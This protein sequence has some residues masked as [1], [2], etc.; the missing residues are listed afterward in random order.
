MTKKADL[1]KTDTD[2][3]KAR[4]LATRSAKQQWTRL[5]TDTKAKKKE[6]RDDLAK[7]TKAIN[8]HCPETE[9]DLPPD[10]KAWLVMN[11]KL[12]NDRKAIEAKKKRELGK[13]KKRLKRAWAAWCEL[14]STE[15]GDQVPMP[16]GDATLA[17]GL[18]CSLASAR[19]VYSEILVRETSGAKLG[20]DLLALKAHLER[21]EG[22]TAFT[23]EEDEEGAEDEED[24][25]D[26]DED[27]EPAEASPD[28]TPE[29]A[30]TDAGAPQLEAV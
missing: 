15:D 11:I 8:E 26:E 10:C 30:A 4:V 29:A 1:K 14:S 28:S 19:V 5:D 21:Q 17:E 3:Y 20:G 23:D 12:V 6:F 27:E 7:A 24:D 22:C 2:T 13:L 25:D 18:G 16:L 9:H